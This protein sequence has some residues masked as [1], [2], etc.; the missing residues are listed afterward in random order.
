[1]RMFGVDGDPVADYSILRTCRKAVLGCPD[2]PKLGWE[3]RGSEL[4]PKWRNWQTR[5]VQGAVSNCS[6]GFK[7][8]L[9]HS[10]F[11]RE[12][13]PGMLGYL[14]PSAGRDQPSPAPHPQNRAGGQD[15]YLLSQAQPPTRNLQLRGNLRG[16]AIM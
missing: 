8:P 15:A 13:L 3:A 14:V 1:M 6:W 7:S 9:R 4:L 11:S 16:G 10:H 2:L 12:T 5:C